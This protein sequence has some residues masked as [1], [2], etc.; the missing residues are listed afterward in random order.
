ML[1]VTV[2]SVTNKYTKVTTCI[3]QL[4]YLI[5]IPKY[6]FKED[7]ESW[8]YSEIGHYYREVLINSSQNKQAIFIFNC[9]DGNS[10]KN[11][12]KIL[13][14]IQDNEENCENQ[15]YT[16]TQCVTRNE[17]G[18]FKQK[19]TKFNFIQND[20]CEYCTNL[21]GDVSSSVSNFKMTNLECN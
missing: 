14:F 20:K 5:I 16:F 3:D 15:I 13:K 18:T 4:T 2:L 11:I 7:I 19:F 17:L 21:Q 9:D 1:P 8:I 10:Q 12:I 6:Y